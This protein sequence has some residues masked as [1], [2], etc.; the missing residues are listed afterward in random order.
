MKDSGKQ[1]YPLVDRNIRLAVTKS[2]AMGRSRT[3]DDLAS[4]T[5]RRFPRIVR[6]WRWLRHAKDD[7]RRTV[8]LWGAALLLL[9]LAVVPRTITYRSEFLV[10]GA[11]QKE[12]WEYVADFANMPTLNPTM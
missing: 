3:L 10:L 4:L 7:W 8:V 11:D 6:L 1:S 5:R 12:V 9:Y 2:L